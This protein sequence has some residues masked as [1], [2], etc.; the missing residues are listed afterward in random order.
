MQY[1]TYDESNFTVNGNC[2]YVMSRDVL[3]NDQGEKHAF[4]VLV[5]NHP[6][7]NTP[8]K[9]CVGK[10]TI[11]YQGHKI[12]ILLDEFRNKLKLIV[13]SERVTDFDDIADWAAVKETATK[14]MKFLLTAVQ[15]EVS[16]YFPSLGVSVKAPSHKYRSRLEGL[17]GNCNSDPSDDTRTPQGERVT[18][19]E[20][21]GLSWLYENLPGGQTREQC[22]PPK[23]EECSPLPPSDD[24]CV[25]LV[26]VNKFGQC[27]NVLD[28]SLFIDWCKKDTCGGHPELSC[29]AIE[30]YARDCAHAGFCIHWRNDEYC[31][32]KA[33]PPGQLYD[34]CGT[35][36]PETCD[37]LKV[38]AKGG[39]R[40]TKR[41]MPTEGCYCPEGQVFLNDTCVS[42]KDCEVCDEEGHHPGDVW[43]KDK[44]TTCT[45]EGTNVKCETQRCSGPKICEKGYNA[46]KIPTGEEECCDEYTCVPEPTAGP[47]CEPPQKLVCGE[48]QILKLDSKPN[49]CQ[50]FICE[51]KPKGDCDPIDLAGSTL[52]EPGYA[53]EI[54]DSGCCPVARKVCKKDLCPPPKECP[55]YHLLKT[56]D[57][58][59]G[60]EMNLQVVQAVYYKNST[61][62]SC[63]W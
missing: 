5:T 9:M 25:Q 7:K 3:S 63:N 16:V 12:H 24:P 31:P 32:A 56:L 48:G 49:G 51:C 59:E 39:A 6:C 19:G 35:S 15:V 26:D 62:T 58:N 10:I 27:L 43:K 42:P 57:D 50:T 41:D 8:S 61:V 14:H 11:L 13:D 1:V 60:M 23:Q 55:E 46:I 29:G 2:V 37:T 54:D 28:P 21:L 40:K 30:A 4:Q 47:T 45:C 36:Q 33:C 34:A 20:E 44:C 53:K 17:C 52:L 38:K 18:D 22:A